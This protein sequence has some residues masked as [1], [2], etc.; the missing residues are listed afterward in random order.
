MISYQV[1]EH[2]KP[3]QRVLSQKPQPRGSEVLV[4]IT[5]TDGDDRLDKAEHLMPLAR[6]DA[7]LLMWL[8]EPQSLLPRAAQAHGVLAVVVG[9]SAST[10]RGST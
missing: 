8:V 3:R 4:R 2:G 1:V 10:S 7:G 9:M 6:L 5:D